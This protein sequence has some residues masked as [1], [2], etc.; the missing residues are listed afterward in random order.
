MSMQCCIIRCTATLYAENLKRDLPRIPLLSQQ[1]AFASCVRIGKALMEL[2]LNYETMKEYRLKWVENKDVPIS[3][4][5][6][7]MKLINREGL[8]QS[9]R[10]A[11]ADRNT[12]RVLS[13]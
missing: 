2:H 12:A 11:D 3:W 5:V 1:E 8:S 13:I 7:K 9:Q 4:R 6:E 10:V